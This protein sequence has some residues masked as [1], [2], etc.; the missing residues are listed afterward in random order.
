[1]AY[2]KGNKITTFAGTGPDKID[3]FKHDVDND[4][5]RKGPGSEPERRYPVRIDPGRINPER[6]DPAIPEH[7]EGGKQELKE[8]TD[9]AIP[10]Q[11]GPHGL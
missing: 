4:P 9:P 3:P 10:E 5:T 11:A 2:Q 6:I 8:G 7:E 1:M